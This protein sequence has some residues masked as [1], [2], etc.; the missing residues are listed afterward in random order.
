MTLSR[1]FSNIFLA[2]TLVLLASCGGRDKNTSA[3]GTGSS[4][5]NGQNSSVESE[6]RSIQE[7]EEQLKNS[8]LEFKEDVISGGVVFDTKPKEAREKDAQARGQLNELYRN[9]ISC[10]DRF[11]NLGESFHSKYHNSPALN[12]SQEELLRKKIERSQKAK[13]IVS[14]AIQERDPSVPPV[15]PTDPTDSTIPYH[16]ENPRDND[17]YKQAKDKLNM[18]E[19]CLGEVGLVFVIYPSQ[20]GWNQNAVNAYMY[21]DG[22]RSLGS[23]HRKLSRMLFQ[24]YRYRSMGKGFLDAYNTSDFLNSDEVEMAQRKLDKVEQTIDDTRRYLKYLEG[25]G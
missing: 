18:A 7:A 24:L 15:Q 21:G 6:Y 16:P 5:G 10:L 2:L 14:E 19:R 12:G 8:G 1:I 3:G 25:N 17:E 9:W 23:L 11:I 22:D 13:K 4:G 20:I